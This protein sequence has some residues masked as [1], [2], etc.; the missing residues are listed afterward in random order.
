MGLGH[1]IRLMACCLLLSTSLFAA[2]IAGKVTNGTTGKPSSGDDVVLLSLVGG[3]QE[4]ARSKTGSRGEFT[5]DVSDEDAQHLIRVTHQGVNYFHPVP[6]GT[7]SADVTVYDAAKKIDN[8]IGEGRVFRVQNAGDQ[9]EVSEMYILRNESKPPRTWMSDRTFEVVLP[10]GAKLEE[11]MA[12]GPGGM[13]VKSSPV[14]TGK[15]NRYAFI[16][17]IRPGRSQLQV[18]YTLGYSGSHDFTISPDIPLAELGVMLPKSMRFDSTG[19]GFSPGQEEQGMAVFVSKSIAPGQQLKFKVSGQGSAPREAQ[20]GGG[21]GS[22]QPEGPGGGL[23]TPSGA[24]APLSNSRWYILGGM[25]VAMAG[26]AVWMV[27]T[28]R[29]RAGGP[30]TVDA[31]AG[32]ALLANSSAPA[33]ASQAVAQPGPQRTTSSSSVLDALKDELF[34]LETDRLQGK[35]SQQEYDAAK[36]GLDALFR[37]HMKRAD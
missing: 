5:F 2:K 14:P 28:M 1:Q 11:G 20:A 7:T 23:G 19:E 36:A 37:R 16:F 4:T 22:S 31:S 17:P 12:A 35:I 26:F 8:L 32:S 10:E 9:L 21:G 6:Q 18:T 34:H 3:M 33:R 13:P 15:D 30:K 24:P 25:L 27:W 29:R